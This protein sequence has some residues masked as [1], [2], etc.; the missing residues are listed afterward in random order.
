MAWIGPG[1]VEEPGRGVGAEPGD[2][3]VLR[4]GQSRDAADG[5]LRDVALDRGGAVDAVG[6]EAVGEAVDE[7]GHV[8]AAAGV[9]LLP[10]EGVGKGDDQAH[11]VDA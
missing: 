6:A 9:V 11:R 5:A 1:R 8:G 10:E 3:V 2:R 7:S 4:A